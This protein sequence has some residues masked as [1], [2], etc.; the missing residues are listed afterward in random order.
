[1]HPTR[2]LSRANLALLLTMAGTGLAAAQPAPVPPIMVPASQEHHPGKDV[3]VLLVTPDLA[4]AKTFYAGLFGWQFRDVPGTVTP[5]AAAFLGDRMVAGVAQRDMPA[6]Q[7]RQP[8]WLGFFSVPDVDQAVSAT[9]SQGGKVLHA[10]HA[11]PGLGTDA[12]LADPQGAVFGVLA[13]S[14][15]DPPDTLKPVGAWIW[16]SLITADPSADAAFYH[17]VLGFE[18]AALPAPAGEQHLLLSSETS[19]G[20]RQTA[21]R[22]AVRRCIRTG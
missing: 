8:A 18:S 14:S 20:R 11:V 22:P 4:A 10:A 13:S 17:A 7:H 12:V 3:F 21:F 15:G 5:Y 6:G 2:R 9:T 19:P 1:M 16:R